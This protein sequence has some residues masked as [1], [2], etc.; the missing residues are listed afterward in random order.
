MGCGEDGIVV[1]MVVCIR[2]C[3]WGESR[4]VRVSS[5][6]SQHSSILAVIAGSEECGSLKNWGGGKK[7]HAVLEGAPSLP[8]LLMATSLSA[9]HSSIWGH[10]S[11]I[12]SEMMLILKRDLLL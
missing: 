1:V 5:K 7:M 11:H 4:V 9:A 3:V 6:R 12:I 8:M 2:T 10:A